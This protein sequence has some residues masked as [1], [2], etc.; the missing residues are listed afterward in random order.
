VKERVKEIFLTE[1]HILRFSDLS[2][3]FLILFI[4]FLV[5]LN[6]IDIDKK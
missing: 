1:L 6:Y 4:G 2:N 5:F 3:P